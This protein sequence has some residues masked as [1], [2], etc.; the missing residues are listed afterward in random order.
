[1][2]KRQDVES[3]LARAEADL[4]QAVTDRAKA[5]AN[6]AEADAKL[7]KARAKR[8][9]QTKRGLMGKR[10]DVEGALARAKADLAQA[11]TDRAEAHAK[12]AESDAKLERA[13]A[14]CRHLHDSL[15]E[16][17]RAEPPP[18]PVTPT[19]GTGTSIQGVVT[20]APSAKRP[21]QTIRRFLQGFL[22]GKLGTANAASRRMIARQAF[23]L[24]ALV[25]AYLQYYFFDVN[26]QVSRMPSITVMVFG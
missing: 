20:E 9:R 26:L 6:V 2:G 4:A 7:E 12:V 1:M 15:V 18:K 25:L 5:H 16:L 3:A 13:R 21:G 24:L 14:V 8:P 22:A 10:Q 11:V 23:M 17:I 19:E